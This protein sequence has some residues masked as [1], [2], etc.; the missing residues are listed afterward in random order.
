MRTASTRKNLGFTLLDILSALTISAILITLVI[1]AFA[2]IVKAADI[3][4]VNQSTLAMLNFARNHAVTHKAQVMICPH[5]TYSC[6]TDWSRPLMIFTDINNNFLRDT[7][8]QVLHIVDLVG[9]NKSLNWKSFGSK[10]YIHF[11]EY[12]TTGYQSGRIYYCDDNSAPDKRTQI[13]IY[14]TGRSRIAHQGE[15]KEGC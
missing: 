11:D 3:R 14:R 10:P 12:G 15:L 6:V 7:E 4:A 2:S 1:P 13:I 8:E 9:G 5:V